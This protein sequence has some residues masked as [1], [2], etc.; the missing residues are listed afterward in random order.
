MN[1]SERRRV[2]LNKLVLCPI[3]KVPVDEVAQAVARLVAEGGDRADGHYLVSLMIAHVRTQHGPAAATV[4]REIAD[5]A[6]GPA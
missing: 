6:M 4:F 3:C 1:R 2:I 5:S